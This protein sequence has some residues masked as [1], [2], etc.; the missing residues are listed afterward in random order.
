[1]SSK[2]E[3]RKFLNCIAYIAMIFAAVTYILMRFTFVPAISEFAVAFLLPV[4]NFFAY[5]V[6]S[7]SAFYYARSKR[8]AVWTILWVI[9]TIIVLV[10][11]VLSVIRI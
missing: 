2:W 8:S 4:A 5:C 1:M 3:F 9:A 7:V 11:L 6:A 10:L